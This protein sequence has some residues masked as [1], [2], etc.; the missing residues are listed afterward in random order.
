[1]TVSSGSERLHGGSAVVVPLMAAPGLAVAA[2]V[3]TWRVV[4]P[5]PG[6][7][8]HEFGP[9]DV[10]TQLQTSGAV[11]ALGLLV[12]A[13]VALVAS[14]RRPS[15]H[16]VSWATAALLA[17]AAAVIAGGWRIMTSGGHGANIG[18]GLVL[19]AGPVLVAVLLVR[20]TAVEVSRR[21]TPGRRAAT[22]MVLA[23]SVAP[24]L[25]A[26]LLGLEA[27]ESSIGVITREQYDAVQV[28]QPRAKVL[29]VLGRPDEPI[30]WFF[31]APPDGTACDYYT[32]E[33]RDGG[34]VFSTVYR[35]CYRADVVVTKDLSESPTG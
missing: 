9:Y 31:A 34:D 20:A 23:G 24:A 25:V 7:P 26:V 1:M 19:V 6:G 30:D 33:H 4:G 10:P 14:V 32:T 12:A 17:S 28:G 2:A 22:L 11:A 15:R 13:L 8:D 35:L 16:V 5:G 21:R 27:Y 18:A 29:D 3:L